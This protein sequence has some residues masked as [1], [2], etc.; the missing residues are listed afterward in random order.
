MYFG[1]TQSLPHTEEQPICKFSLILILLFHHIHLKDTQRKSITECQDSTVHTKSSQLFC[2]STH[3]ILFSIIC[4]AARFKKKNNVQLNKLKLIFSC[5]L[6]EQK[7]IKPRQ[8]P[9]F[10]FFLMLTRF[11]IPINGLRLYHPRQP[12]KWRCYNILFWKGIWWF[13]RWEIIKSW[14]WNVRELWSHVLQYFNTSNN[15]G[16]H[17]N[18][19]F[20]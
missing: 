1:E 11:F 10:F 9:S 4:N 8:K 16:I 13:D 5:L 6:R 18:Y 15:R 2:I 19:I 14:I 3:F 12:L 17:S 20:L 7:Y